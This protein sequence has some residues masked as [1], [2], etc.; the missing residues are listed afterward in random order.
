MAQID[1]DKA[2]KIT[3]RFGAVIDEYMG[4]ENEGDLDPNVLL[5]HVQAVALVDIA[6]SLRIIAED[7][8]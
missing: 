6:R 4:T 5:Q 7:Y 3:D 8:K 2:Q 1:L